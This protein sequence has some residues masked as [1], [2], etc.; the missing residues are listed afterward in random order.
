MRVVACGAEPI[1]PSALRAFS[2]ATGIPESAHLP[3]YGLAEATLAVAAPRRGGIRARAIDGIERVIV[4]PPLPGVEI[5]I[6]NGAGEVVPG[7]GEIEVRGAGVAAGYWRDP[8][9]TAGLHRDGWMRTGN[10]GLLDG[11]ELVVTG[12]SKDVVI[13]DGRNVHAADVEELVER[14][15]GVKPGGS[16]FVAD[17]RAHPERGVVALVLADGEAWRVLPRVA[18]LVRGEIGAPVSVVAIDRVPR[19]TSGKKR[20]AEVRARVAAGALDRAPHASTL[21]LVRAAW[22][23]ALGRPVIDDHSE[24]RDLGGTSLQAVRIMAAIAARGGVAPDHRLL[25]RASTVHA[26][27]CLLESEQEAPEV[28][29]PG[30]ASIAIVSLAL[31]VPGAS[32][33]R[34][35]FALA[36]DKRCMIGPAPA[37][38]GMGGVAGG[39]VDDVN[40]FDAQRFAIAADE[41]AA[42]DPQQRIMLTVASEAL[43]RAGLSDDQRRACGVFVGAGHQAYLEH[44]LPHVAGGARSLP[45][46]A[47]AGNLLEH[48][49]GPRGERVRSARTGA[50]SGHRLLVVAGRAPRRL[51]VAARRRLRR[52]DHRRRPPQPVAHS[53]HAVL[54]RR[55]SVADRPVPPVPGRRGR[56]RAR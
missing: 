15:P 41:A 43:E 1:D 18:T 38:R 9:A 6:V 7:E 12:R 19:T 17:A 44:V 16:V 33:P 35:L 10:L 30:A 32:G 29:G 20:R 46:G 8:E 51:P 42:M 34:S 5:R 22:S 36:A 37:A 24:L 39:F 4:G 52:R 48:D 11:G 3:L 27:A 26:L 28:A 21:A 45:P 40:M 14:V 25:A 23:D 54:S 13:V 56:H 53:V 55:C 50:L 49:R 2:A 31:R 47:L